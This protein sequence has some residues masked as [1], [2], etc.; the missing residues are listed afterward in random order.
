MRKDAMPF[1]LR[2]QEQ[3]EQPRE[4]QLHR[5]FFQESPHKGKT[6]SSRHLNA[7]L[8]HMSILRTVPTQASSEPDNFLRKFSS[9]VDLISHVCSM[10]VT[11]GISR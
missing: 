10:A 9:C 11:S 8:L 1:P 6:Q 3:L 4:P 2:L 5:G 7:A